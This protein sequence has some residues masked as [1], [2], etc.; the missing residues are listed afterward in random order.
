MTDRLSAYVEHRMI[1]RRF[2]PFVLLSLVTTSVPNALSVT[3]LA[4]ELSL[5]NTAPTSS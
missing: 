2:L 3:V 4:D 1:N 5:R